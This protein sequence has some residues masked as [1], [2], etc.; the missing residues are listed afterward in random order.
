MSSR[1]FPTGKIIVRAAEVVL[2]AWIIKGALALYSAGKQ[3]IAV[4]EAILAVAIVAVVETLM[5]LVPLLVAWGEGRWQMSSDEV[6]FRGI[7]VTII[8]AMIADGASWLITGEGLG[9]NHFGCL[10]AV[11]ILEGIIPGS[12]GPI[13]GNRSWPGL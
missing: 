7:Q 1:K 8:S 11:V 6:L 5:W 4:Q 13:L 3:E 9:V 12:F 10:I 2:A